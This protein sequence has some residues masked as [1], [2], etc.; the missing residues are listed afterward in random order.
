MSNGD[1]RRL[2]ESMTPM[3][4][5]VW[6]HPA[7]GDKGGSRA[8]NRAPIVTVFGAGVAGLSAAHELIERGFA[9]QVV[10]AARS[11]T[12]EY[13]CEVGG[14]AANQWGRI[15]ADV[16]RLHPH[17]FEEDGSEYL[18]DCVDQLGDDGS[19]L[20]TDVFEGKQQLLNDDEV[21]DYRALVRE[22]GHGAL[23]PVQP[24]FPT[25]QRIVFLGDWGI[26]Q[27]ES[28]TE[29]GKLGLD[30][31]A[32]DVWGRSNE[33]KLIE[34]WQTLRR[35][36]E[37]YAAELPPQLDVDEV[38]GNPE[39]QRIRRREIL[40]MEIRGRTDSDGDP[41]QN[42]QRGK[43]WGCA[44]KRFLLHL[45]EAE[46]PERRIPDL[47]RHLVVIG[48][49]STGPI[50][51]QRRRLER[52]QSCFV[53]FRIVEHTVPGEHGYRFFP[54]FYRH[55]F[56]AMRR[57]PILD[58][59]GRET[60]ATTYDHLVPTT[61]VGLAMDDARKP[62]TFSRTRWS[63]EEFRRSLEVLTQDMG[64]TARDRAR[65]EA[66]M[67]KFMTSCTRRR[68]EEYEDISWW[69][70]LG[71]RDGIGYSER[72][73]AMLRKTPQAL[74]AMSAEETDARTHGNVSIQL[75]LD[76]FGS[77]QNVDMTLNGPT[78]NAWL[79]HWKIYLKRQGVRFFVGRLKALCV[80]DGEVYPVVE[81]DYDDRPMPVP[82]VSTH[83]YLQFGS[84]HG[85]PDFYV[86]A[87]PFDQARDLVLSLEQGEDAIALDGDFA[88]LK[89]F[90]EA[91][92]SAR[93][94]PRKVERDRYGR[95]PWNDPFRELSGIQYYFGNHVRIGHG[96]TYYPNSAWGLSSISQVAHWRIRL[97]PTS[98][99]LGQ[100]SVDIGDFYTP[101]SANPRI[102]AWHATR[103]EIA[104][105][106]WN[107]VLH[108]LERKY[109][110]RVHPPTY[111]HL[112]QGL[113]F[114]DQLEGFSG[115]PAEARIVYNKTAFL[116]N[117]PD[118]WKYRPGV[119]SPGHL[120]ALEPALPQDEPE[121]EIWYE[122]S[123]KR[124]MLTGMYMAT[125][126]RLSTMEVSNES[127]R[128]TVN[129]ILRQI[130]QDDHE[131][132]SYHG[133]GRLMGDF[134]Q[135][136]PPEDNELDDLKPI[137]RLDEKLIEA[138]LPHAFDILRILD[139]VDH[140]PE[141]G[142]AGVTPTG[143]VGRLLALLEQ[144]GLSL[145]QDW[146]F[147]RE[148][149]GPSAREFVRKLALENV[150]DLLET[151]GGVVRQWAEKRSRPSDENGE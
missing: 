124:W 147:L 106:T 151:L 90:D 132:P 45:N 120:G 142:E 54:A 141:V 38:S 80:Q 1:D 26:P 24:I 28:G 91:T 44:V 35:A 109:A 41:E 74:V 99:F 3:D 111:Y 140:I 148:T 7:G 12:E 16:A 146:N 98:A 125:H 110:L 102:S 135:I 130:M 9:V 11:N 129:A 47:D 131:N 107:Q 56:D 69:E 20:D 14:M 95:P 34:V 116:I 29:W 93:R 18:A 100:L 59:Q 27:G 89:A 33:V 108:G 105:I 10:E 8:E 81:N 128:H 72:S 85:A 97:S 119:Y 23:I 37:R 52:E 63:L 32:A 71:G 122:V 53:E 115:D 92:D 113:V 22:V 65:F 67:W 134:C 96:H 123:H 86:L 66:R 4:I 87:L 139:A 121:P 2:T 50:G 36:Y 149:Y 144:G 117:L 127:A 46:P 15:R 103:R 43:R 112:D 136:W 133:A 94:D 143:P 40:V 19:I 82:E 137:K 73:A 39:R 70:Y 31:A 78:S 17:Y 104:K 75:F 84:A 76:Q 48:V 51:S 62:R 55:L 64:V 83:E 77:G 68:K 150:D 145:T 30:P 118:Q 88:K 21:A 42:R 138:G 58:E 61:E 79:R 25:P 57:T 114:E 60:G 6:E 5:D 13:A 101:N 49:G 126:T